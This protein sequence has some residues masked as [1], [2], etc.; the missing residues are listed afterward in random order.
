MTEEK[1]RRHA[2]RVLVTWNAALPEAQCCTLLR[3]IAKRR[4]HLRAL[5]GR[6]RRW[7]QGTMRGGRKPTVASTQKQVDAWLRAR[8]MQE[9]F[10]VEVSKEEGLPK[11][12]YRFQRRAWEQLQRTLL[13]KTLIFTDSHDCSDADLVRGYRAQHHVES[14]FRQMQ[15]T[16]C[17][18][19]RPQHHW[20]DHK[21]AVHALCC[22]LALALC[23]LLQ[24]ELDGQGVRR[25]IPALLRELAEIREVEVLYPPR[26]EGGQPTIQTTLSKTT[27]EQRQ[28]FEILGLGDCTA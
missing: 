10:R 12:R 5:Q 8:L 18:A 6:L 4:Q 24:R 27:D 17:I 9:L 15:D 26:R 23:G 21:I 28:M 2:A 25:S 7:R 1:R 20:T 13:G 11:V 22:V 16:D 14:A 19:I 3:E